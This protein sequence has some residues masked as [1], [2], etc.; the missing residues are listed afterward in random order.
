MPG[1]AGPI[2]RWRNPGS[3][4]PGRRTKGI[5]IEIGRRHPVRVIFIHAKGNRAD[6]LLARRH[7]G[8][9][10]VAR[11]GDD[12]PAHLPEDAVLIVAATKDHR[13]I[14]LSG[15]AEIQAR[16]DGQEGFVC[17]RVLMREAERRVLAQDQL[18]A[19][20]SHP[21]TLVVASRRGHGIGKDSSVGRGLRTAALAAIAD[22]NGNKSRR[23]FAAQRD[24]RTPGR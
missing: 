15:V 17:R 22:D 2:P 23:C 1:T 7:E 10:T 14:T 4:G 9:M 24:I 6:R 13:A 19:A 5:T 18:R 21:E 12:R 16:R 8:A 3:R 11:F 20:R